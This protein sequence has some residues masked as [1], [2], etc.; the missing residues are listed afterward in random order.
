MACDGR[1]LNFK[2]YKPYGFLHVSV[3]GAI[4][5]M[6]LYAF[7]SICESQLQVQGVYH[8]RIKKSSKE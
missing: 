6:I 1:C 3:K 7:L 5:L 2:I 4:N 8:L